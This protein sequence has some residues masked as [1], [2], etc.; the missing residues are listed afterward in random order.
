MLAL[1]GN[2]GVNG[3]YN[4]GFNNR[5]P[6]YYA[7]NISFW[8]YA[9]TIE[10]DHYGRWYTTLLGGLSL[11]L[12]KPNNIGGL[13]PP[14]PKKFKSFGISLSAGWIDECGSDRPDKRELE[15]F[16]SG[17]SRNITAGYLF[18]SGYTWAAGRR[19]FELGLSS[20]QVAFNV[21]YSSQITPTF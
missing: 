10:R 12:P 7:L 1:G 2:T 14:V 20:P 3:M 17:W 6:D 18:S 16:L 13:K 8:D 4:S 21:P 19:S 15:E 9:L 5:T 11:E